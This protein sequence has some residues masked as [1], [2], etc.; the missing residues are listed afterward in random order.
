MSN[1]ICSGQKVDT[2]SLSSM[3][4]HADLVSSFCLG[5]QDI[6]KIDEKKPE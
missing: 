6:E 4:D 2:G 5:F 1:Y 3:K